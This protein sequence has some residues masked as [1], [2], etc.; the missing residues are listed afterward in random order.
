M[1]MRAAFG[2]KGIAA[3]AALAVLVGAGFLR[4]AEIPQLRRIASVNLCAD[5]MLLSLAPAGKIAALGPFAKDPLISFLARRASSFPQLLG[6]SEELVSIE[7]DAVAVGPFDNRF[8]R[9]ALRRRQ[10]DEIVVDRW[11]NLSEVRRGVQDFAERIG[12]AAAG[13]ALIAEI[14]RE[15]VSLRGAGNGAPPT[16]F[17]LLHRRGFVGEG[18]IVS[19]LL[20]IAGL[21]DAAKDASPRFMSVEAIISLRP[22]F[23]VVTE[24]RFKA[25]DRGLELLEHSA[26]RRLYPESRRI[27]APDRLTICAG[28]STPALIRHLKNELDGRV[29]RR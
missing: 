1:A 13:G 11:T 6:R 14:D 15:V 25:E 26:L 18:G 4:A 22:A 24:P 20:E 3:L 16:S 21:R 5:Q 2:A 7:A 12:E 28:P 29:G 23:L 9:A 8:M 27:A 17:V 19:E 10:I